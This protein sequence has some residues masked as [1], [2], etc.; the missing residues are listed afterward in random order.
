MFNMG[1][2]HKHFLKFVWILM[3]D[4]CTYLAY[5]CR[6]RLSPADSYCCS[7]LQLLAAG[8]V[9]ELLFLFTPGSVEDPGFPRGVPT[10]ELSARTYYLANFW[11]RLHENERNGPSGTWTSLVPPGS[12]TQF[13]ILII[14]WW[15]W[16]RSLYLWHI[17]SCR[18]G[19]EH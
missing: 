13:K 16:W 14:F 7:W 12:S 4:F 2:K 5:F 19:V 11:R 10:S 9:R 17:W 8:I 18:F 3:P 15:K 6:S 1:S